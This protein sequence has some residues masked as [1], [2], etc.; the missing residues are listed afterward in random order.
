MQ[1]PIKMTLHEWMYEYKTAFDLPNHWRTF[2]YVLQGSI[3]YTGNRVSTRMGF[4][5]HVW[6]VIG[7][8]VFPECTR[9]FFFV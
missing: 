6:A 9:V 8:L 2:S 1:I 3:G 5:H 4:S 7:I